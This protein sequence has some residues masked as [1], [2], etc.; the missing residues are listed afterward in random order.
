MFTLLRLPMQYDLLESILK[1]LIQNIPINFQSELI[2]L[3]NLV[4]VSELKK[5]LSKKTKSDPLVVLSLQF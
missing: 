3:I 1:T 2:V 5:Y 4:T